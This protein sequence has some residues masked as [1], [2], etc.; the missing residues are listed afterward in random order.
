MIEKIKSFL[1]WEGP[2]QHVRFRHFKKAISKLPLKPNLKVLD[3]GAG[4]GSYSIFIAKKIPGSQIKAIDV[5]EAE[6]EVLRHKLPDDSKSKISVKKESVTDNQGRE[7][8]DLVICVDVLEHVDDDLLALKNL[9]ESLKK[10]GL[11]F[12]HVPYPEPKR[13]LKQFVYKGNLRSQKGV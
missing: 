4:Q 3:A 5:D 13:Y 1:G 9:K 12:L 8:Y 10:N 7:E 6:L 11:L 2:G